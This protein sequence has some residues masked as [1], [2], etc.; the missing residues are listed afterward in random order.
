MVGT[1][2]AEPLSMDVPPIAMVGTCI[3]L[4]VVGSGASAEP[5][6][7]TQLHVIGVDPPLVYIETRFSIKKRTMIAMTTQ[8]RCTGFILCV[9]R[10]FFQ[11][12][13]AI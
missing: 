7:G 4:A 9:L 12:V 1:C 2:I 6:V 3:A 13:Q 8:Q 5:P 10:R 11:V